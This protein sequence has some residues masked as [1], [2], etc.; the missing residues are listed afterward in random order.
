MRLGAIASSE[1]KFSVIS[2]RT[3]AGAMDSG[4][5]SW[6]I[7]EQEKYGHCMKRDSVRPEFVV[8]CIVFAHGSRNFALFTAGCEV[9]DL[10]A[11]GNIF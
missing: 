5:H 7:V 4:C 11:D 1:S 9:N 6:L 2:R 8:T 3:L 10:G